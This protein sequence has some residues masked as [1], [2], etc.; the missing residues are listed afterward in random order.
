MGKVKKKTQITEVGN[1]TKSFW[2]SNISYDSKLDNVTV[3]FTSNKLEEANK[4]LS[5]LE[6]PKI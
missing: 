4:I 6:L 3:A 1:T 2:G 5:N